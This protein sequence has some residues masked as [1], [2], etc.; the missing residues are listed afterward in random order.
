MECTKYVRVQAW[1]R[2]FEQSVY[3]VCVPRCF[4]KYVVIVMVMCYCYGD[5]L[6]LWWRV[7]VMVTCYCYGD[8]L[9]LWR[10]VTVMAT[11]YCYGDVLL[12]WWRVTVMVTCYCYGDVLLLWGCVTVMVMCYLHPYQAST[13]TGTAYWLRAPTG[14]KLKNW[15]SSHTMFM[16]F[17]FISEQTATFAPYKIK[18][19]FF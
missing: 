12:L 1:T 8:V 17:V 3:V 5:V 16:Y 18:L 2:A 13:R 15:H 11:C 7:T 4:I 9:L 14:L 6:L 10:R 19:L